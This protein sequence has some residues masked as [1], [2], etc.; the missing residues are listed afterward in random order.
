MK[1]GFK[2]I[3]LAS[4]FIPSM[5]R[6]A[7][8]QIY[9]S[10]LDFELKSGQQDAKTLTVTNPTA[11]IQLFE[12]SAE[13]FSQLIR[14][15][16]ASFTLEP[17]EKKNVQVSVKSPLSGQTIAAEVSLTGRPLKESSLLVGAG[18]KIPVV[19]TSQKT[20]ETSKNKPAIL[21]LLT[22]I[23]IGLLYYSNKSDKLAKK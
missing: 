7:G 10:R 23:F 9:P 16:P 13:G 20:E 12:I 3:L 17:G 2:I 14:T 6:A 1:N 22:L 5:V 11:D 4:L 18:V 19:I 21:T 8:M 15:E